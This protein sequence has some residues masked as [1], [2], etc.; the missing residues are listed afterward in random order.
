M[1]SALAP[2][3]TRLVLRDVRIRGALVQLGADAIDRDAWDW[4]AV[5]ENPFFCPDRAAATRWEAV[6]GEVRKSGSSVG[7]IVE[8]QAEVGG[9][10]DAG[11]EGREERPDAVRGGQ[12]CALEE[13]QE[14][15]HE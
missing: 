3:P 4:A 10:Q 12:A 2:G 8:V 5:E 6:L 14:V 9:G 1:R 13:V 7:A 15:V 11:Q